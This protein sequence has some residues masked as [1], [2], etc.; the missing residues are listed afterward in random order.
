MPK[1][2]KST[3]VKVQSEMEEAPQD[4]GYS[5]EELAESDA[6][7]AFIDVEPEETQAPEPEPDTEP[8]EE[9]QAEEA[10]EEP[11]PE[12][13]PSET[14]GEPTREEREIELKG[15]TLKELKELAAGDYDL[16]VGG[17]KP[18]LLKRILNHEYPGEAPKQSGPRQRVRSETQRSVPAARTTDLLFTP[19][20]DVKEY[21]RVLYYGREGSAKTTNLL[22]M[23]NRGRILFINAEGGVKKRALQARGINL[24]NVAVWPPEGQEISYQSLRDV[25]FQIKSDLEDNPESWFGIG[26]DSITDIVQG[27]LDQV[28]THRVEK[29]RNR[30]V[31][32]DLVDSFFVD[33]DDYGTMSKMMRKLM[34]DFRDLPT[35]VVYTALERRDV[36]ED[37]GKVAYG[38][39]LSPAVGTD[40]MGYVD[41]VLYCRAADED[42]EVFRA[43]TK[44]A[45][46]YRVKDRD[47]VLPRVLVNPTMPRILEYVEGTITEPE[48]EDQK[49]LKAPEPKQQTTGKKPGA[50][51][52]RTRKNQET[53]TTTTEQE[54]N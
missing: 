54:N 16:P 27:I 18:T 44:Q 45:G 42:Q 6:A 12:E 43:V 24:D 15:K 14:D 1:I 41:L 46:K 9:P 34:R 35:H 52:T 4:S 20:G 40:L 48:D 10:P 22:S 13:E 53:T 8:E 32:V 26:F 23:A 28:S 39:A 17:T 5:P 29:T 7:M 33:R 11:A 30:G 19:L 2:E 21:S 31:D 51:P 47:G 49:L 25:Y 36:D 38:P 37:S 3:R 50:R